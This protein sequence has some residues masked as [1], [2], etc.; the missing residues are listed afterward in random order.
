MNKKIIDKRNKNFKK[1]S[2]FLTNV[3]QINSKQRLH[4]TPGQTKAL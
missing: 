3:R 1:N 2:I 4:D